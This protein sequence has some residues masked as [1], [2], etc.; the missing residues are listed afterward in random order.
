MRHRVA[1]I[2][3]VVAATGS[4][5][6]PA[7]AGSNNDHYVELLSGTIPAIVAGDTVWVSLTWQAHGADLEQFRVVATSNDPIPTSYPANTVDHS[8]LWADD[9]LTEGEIDFTALKLAVPY[10]IDGPASWTIDVS[11]RPD[12]KNGPTR[13]EAPAANKVAGASGKVTFQIAIDQFTGQDVSLVQ[14]T[15][16]QV[17]A[18][19]GAWVDVA[20]SGHAPFV[21]DFAVTLSDSAGFGVEYPQ[22]T[23]T[24]LVHDARLDDAETDVAR[25]YL[26]ATGVEPGMH[27]L[28]VLATWDRGGVAGQLSGVLS[29]EVVAP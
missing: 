20:F 29:V 14:A 2:L 28:G 15:V 22:G 6:S 8:S 26:D 10:G 5:A 1:A 7:S 13:V 4:L 3:A 12:G 16:Q 24:S 25:L 21:S 11:Y 19:G 18:D 23:F 9:E 17:P 27:D